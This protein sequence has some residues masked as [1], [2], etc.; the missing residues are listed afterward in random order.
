[1]VAIALHEKGRAALKEHNYAK[2]LISF[3]N[4]DQEFRYGSWIDVF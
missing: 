2:A 4:A 1:M 3:L